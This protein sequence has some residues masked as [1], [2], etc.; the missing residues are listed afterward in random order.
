[1]NNEIINGNFYCR[2]PDRSQFWVGVSVFLDSAGG[3][4]P[5]NL[6]G[7]KNGLRTHGQSCT[8][9]TVGINTI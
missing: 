9:T 2:F 5:A 4:L 3:R 1:M 7:A 6:V 8:M